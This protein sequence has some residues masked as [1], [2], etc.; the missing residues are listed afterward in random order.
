MAVGPPRSPRA[1]P[2]AAGVWPRR[3]SAC[4]RCA[5]SADPAV[6]RESV[7]PFVLS[8]RLRHDNL[9]SLSRPARMRWLRRQLGGRACGWRP[10]PR[11]VRWRWTAFPPPMPTVYFLCLCVLPS[12]ASCLTVRVWFSNAV[13]VWGGGERLQRGVVA[14]GRAGEAARWL[15]VEL[16]RCLAVVPSQ[17][18]PVLPFF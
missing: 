5:A 8:F 14:G 2:A 7:P 6:D 16:R 18:L 10:L 9:T 13:E 15:R 11:R 17:P 3:S 12:L 4:D 1:M